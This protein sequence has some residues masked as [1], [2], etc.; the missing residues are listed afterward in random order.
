MAPLVGCPCLTPEFLQ[1][2][3]RYLGEKRWAEPVQLSTNPPRNKHLYPNHLPP[4]AK[5][6]EPAV[7]LRQQ[8]VGKRG[9]P[10][11]IKVVNCGI[12]HLKTGRV[13]LATI[14]SRQKGALMRDSV[15]HSHSS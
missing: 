8:R 6:P 7:R 15:R 4:P 2:L 1:R 5:P 14:R 10:E 3:V 13:P 9:T 12:C 11:I